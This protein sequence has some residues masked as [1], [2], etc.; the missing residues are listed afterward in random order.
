MNTCDTCKWWDLEAK[1][2]AWVGGV[3]LGEITELYGACTNP[4][5]E[6]DKPTSYVSGEYVDGYGNKHEVENPPDIPMGG[7]AASCSN[8]MA[9]IKTGPK[10]GC[11]HYETK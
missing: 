4:K 10:F 7:L 11:I 8:Y 3:Q 1:K 5:L 9:W 6:M 2:G